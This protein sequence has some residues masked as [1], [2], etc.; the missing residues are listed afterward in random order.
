MDLTAPRSD[1]GR[2]TD[3]VAEIIAALASRSRLEIVR[4][5]VDTE[6]D[7]TD[8]AQRLGASVATTSHHLGPLRRAGL[9]TSRRDGTRILN[10]IAGPRVLDLCVAP[11]AVAHPSRRLDAVGP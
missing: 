11:C 8:I 4:L 7:V 10:R 6:L 3:D 2:D 9:V 1:A 5:L